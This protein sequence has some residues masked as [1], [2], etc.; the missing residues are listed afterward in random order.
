MVLIIVLLKIYFE[1]VMKGKFLGGFFIDFL[2]EFAK[3][4]FIYSANCF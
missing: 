3:E 2:I 4:F 1:Q